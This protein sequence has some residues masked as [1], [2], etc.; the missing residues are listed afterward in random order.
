MNNRT[1]RFVF[2]YLKSFNGAAAARRAGYAESSAPVVASQLLKRE[3]VQ[4]QIQI[5]LEKIKLGADHVLSILAQI[6]TA[7]IGDFLIEDK[8][9]DE[10]GVVNETLK[11][12][13][14]A[15]LD[16]GHLIKS[17]KMTKFGPQIELHEKIPVLNLLGKYFRLFSENQINWE[18]KTPDGFSYD[19]MK[20]KFIEALKND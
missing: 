1:E 17:L 19:E 7:N 4:T 15:V 20:Q 16:N 11:L 9:I 5:E 6:A 10:D 14:Q 2:E 12:D 18:Q 3:D 8:L 13:V